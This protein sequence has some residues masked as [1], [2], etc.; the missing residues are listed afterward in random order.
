MFSH[1]S[2]ARRSKSATLFGGGWRR[3]R[4]FNTSQRCSM[5]L[6][7]GLLAGHGRTMIRL[8]WS[9]CI[10]PRAVWQVDCFA[11][12]TSLCLPVYVEL[13]QGRHSHP[14]SAWHLDSLEPVQ[15]VFLCAWK[16]Q[17]TSLWIFHRNGLP[18]QHTR[19]DN[20][21]LGD[22]RST[23]FRPPSASLFLFRPRIERCS[24]QYAKAANVDVPI[25]NELA[26][27]LPLEL[28][29]SWGVGSV[30]PPPE[31][32]SVLSVERSDVQF[33]HLFALPFLKLVQIGH[34][35]AWTRCGCPD[36]GLICGSWGGGAC[37]RHFL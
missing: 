12:E 28:P 22:G 29:P 6:S 35:R 7:H 15:V 2:V 36:D 3:I 26:D 23:I 11:Q 13:W 24:T 14:G 27:V 32:A 17:P 20:A 34:A 18:R 33:D 4:R 10:V 9:I 21:R 5:G 25:A 31:D 16:C 19:H 30:N 8:S 1:P 37:L